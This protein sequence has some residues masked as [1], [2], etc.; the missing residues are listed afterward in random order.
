[1]D[2][3]ALSFVCLGA[4]YVASRI[5][6]F[7][8]KHLYFKNHTVAITEIL[9]RLESRLETCPTCEAVNAAAATATKIDVEAP[10]KN[11]VELE[12]GLPEP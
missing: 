9:K 11:T 8:V 12:N 5:I 4:I 1:M 3:Y 7:M 2:Q 10:T 6:M